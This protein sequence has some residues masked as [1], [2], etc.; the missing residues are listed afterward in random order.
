M[1]SARHVIK[2][3]LNFHFLS[4]MACYAMASNVHQSLPFAHD[5][6]LLDA[7]A[8]ADLALLVPRQV[9]D[10]VLLE[11]LAVI[12][13]NRVASSSPFRIRILRHGP[14]RC[15]HSSTFRVNVRIFLRDTLDALMEFW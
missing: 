9:R 13:E 6:L 1:D 4:K 3:I 8:H 12:S 5:H 11:Q 10:A 2:S 14:T 7:P 15:L